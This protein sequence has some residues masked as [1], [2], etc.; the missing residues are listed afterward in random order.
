[1]P[2]IK[3]NIINL[4]VDG[5]IIE[6]KKP[7]KLNFELSKALINKDRFQEFALNPKD[8]VAKY[9]LNIDHNIAKQLQEKLVGIESIND[10]NILLN[11]PGDSQTTVYAVAKGSYSMASSKIALAF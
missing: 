11:D 7:S 6:V 4:Q 1:M 3:A 8:F 9:D 2:R 5:K 10:L